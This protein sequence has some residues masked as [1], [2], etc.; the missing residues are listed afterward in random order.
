[1][2][3]IDLP[4]PNFDSRAGSKINF[5]ILHYTDTKTAKEALDILTSP[6]KKVSSHYVVDENG[7]IYSLVKEHD[8]AWHA[9]V[10]SWQGME[11]L[12][13]FS[14]GVEIVNPGH[15]N[16]L[17]KFPEV[18]MKSVLELCQGIIERHKI[19]P[20]YVL[21]HS[22]IA[23]ARK[24]DPGEMFDWQYL[25]SHGVGIFYQPKK[26]PAGL[27]LEEGDKAGQVK[28]FQQ[29]LKKLGYKIPETGVFD[30]ETKE[31]VEAF[32]R[33]FLPMNSVG[34]RGITGKWSAL[35]AEIINGLLAL[36]S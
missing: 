35:E 23:P 5:I 15:L 28:E 31:V 2:N 36:I 12:N 18:Q 16:G 6:E 33:R 32:Q 21:A 11:N 19:K 13:A 1:M 10:S 4:S 20:Q 34:S 14:I 30:V 25:A 26:V 24:K 8:R 29:K 9:G 17:K 3:I 27:T 22:D 7:D